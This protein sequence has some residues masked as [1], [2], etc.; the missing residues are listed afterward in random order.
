MELK[1][2]EQITPIRHRKPV[3]RMLLEP[4]MLLSVV[5][6]GLLVVTGTIDLLLV[7]KD[8]KNGGYAELV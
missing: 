7:S 8:T 1:A 4:K 2:T 5:A 3:D 6:D